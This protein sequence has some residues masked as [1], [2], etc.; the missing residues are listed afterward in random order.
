MIVKA[1]TWNWQ[2]RRLANSTLSLLEQ[3]NETEIIVLELKK[4]K[5]HTQLFGQ[6]KKWRK[7]LSRKFACQQNQGLWWKWGTLQA[8]AEYKV[9][10]V[11]GN[12]ETEFLT[13]T[14]AKIIAKI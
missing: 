9:F 14:F 12:K 6:A 4:K 5:P 8:T 2:L 1:S 3:K 13:V 11:Y 7:K 10:I